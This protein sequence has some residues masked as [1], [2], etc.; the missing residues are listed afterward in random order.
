M[1]SKTTNVCIRMDTKLKEQSE[2]LF[3][4]LGLNLSTAINIFLRKAVRE[5]GIPFRINIDKPNEKT[6]QAMKEAEIITRDPSVKSYNNIQELFSD[7][8]K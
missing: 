7:L 6:L 3:S 1:S 4:Q 8:E 5:G 2:E